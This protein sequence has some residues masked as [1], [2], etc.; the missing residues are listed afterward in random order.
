MQR[1]KGF[2]IGRILRV[3][4]LFLAFFKGVEDKIWYILASV[5]RVETILWA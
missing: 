5:S 1:G 4:K 3:V 2:G